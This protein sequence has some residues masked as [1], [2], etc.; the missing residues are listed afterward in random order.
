MRHP[1]RNLSTI[2]EL[3]AGL[4]DFVTLG[5]PVWYRGQTSA[6][7]KLVPAI[8]RNPDHVK[9]ELTIIKLFKQ[10][11]RPH[12]PDYPKSEWE[13]VF[14]MQHHRAPTRLLDWSESPLVGLYFALWDQL[15][16]HDGE[17]AALW[18]LDPIALNRQSGHRRAFDHDILAFDVDG[19]LDQYLPEQVSARAVDLDPVAAIGPRNSHRMVA[20][21]GTFTIMHARPTP[22]EEVADSQH[23]WRMIIPAAAKPELRT[24]LALLGIS[25]FALFP[26]LDRVAGVARELLR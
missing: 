7:W 15:G 22:V 11:A 8:G 16:K 25:E 18:F 2:S 14:L 21:A 5:Q 26:D 19:N 23:I 20:Q 3:I 6:T 4:R 12:L 17:D 1:D 24:E 9:A 13:W 10:N